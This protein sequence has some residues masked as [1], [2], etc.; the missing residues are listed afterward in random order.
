MITGV[1]SRNSLDVPA[2]EP[3]TVK[4]R[5]VW[6]LH[7]RGIGTR[8]IA[9]ALNLHRSTVVSHLESARRRLALA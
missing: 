8:T 7:R 9:L 2:L 4:Q 1:Q 3:L 6:E 5:E